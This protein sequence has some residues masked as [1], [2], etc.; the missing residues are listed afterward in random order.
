MFNKIE[1]PF[2]YN[3]NMYC[4]YRKKRNRW[5]LEYDLPAQQKILMVI[6]LPRSTSSRRAKEIE[7]FKIKDLMAGKLTDKEYKKLCSRTVNKNL[8]IEEAIDKYRE[9][10]AFNKTRDTRREEKVRLPTLFSFFKKKYKFT[11]I[12]QFKKEH[13]IE[14]RSHLLR[15]AMIRREFVEVVEVKMPLLNDE[16]EKRSLMREIK[17]HGISPATARNKLRDV[18]TVFNC[19]KE[20]GHILI[21]PVLE[22]KAIR[23]QEKD[24]VRSKTFSQEQ[25]FK[26][27]QC[28]YQTDPRVDFPIK[29]FFLF[30]RETGARLKEALYLERDDVVDGIW[31]IKA[32]PNC[33]TKYGLG[34]TPKWGKERQVVLSPTAIKIIELIPVVPS[35]GYIK[36][37][38]HPYPANFVFTII[39]RHLLNLG[40]RRRVDSIVGTWNGLLRSA[41]LP[42]Y[43]LEKLVRHDLR[44]TR[45]VEDKHLNGMSD[46]ERGRRLGN[47]PEVNRRHYA[48]EVDE[49]LLR[50]QARLRRSSG[51]NLLQFI[52]PPLNANSNNLVILEEQKKKDFRQA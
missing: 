46:E 24:S 40:G 23:L 21:N 13:L 27:M 11:H 34:W 45:N 17:N 20:N 50:L 4:Y 52:E 10:T 25:I 37:S 1:V 30:L 43:G 6:T 42:D 32:K 8:T 26:I 14:Y 36:K 47:R 2:D 33:P 7:K 38:H 12:N 9:I 3:P 18:K 28:D 15:E 49:D 19:L 29:K 35:V 39:D 51:D 31:D 48:G 22:V 5:F 16:K 44:R 41:G